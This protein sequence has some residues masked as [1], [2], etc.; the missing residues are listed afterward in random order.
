M[1]RENI[2]RWLRGVYTSATDIGEAMSYFE[3]RCVG[4][5]AL[6]VDYEALAESFLRP[7]SGA[8][9][10]DGRDLERSRKIELRALIGSAIQRNSNWAG[11]PRSD[12]ERMVFCW[13]AEHVYGAD[14]GADEETGA[15]HAAIESELHV[16]KRT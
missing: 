1:D 16:S 7:S 2:N 11:V 4:S 5:A 6:G 14:V 10:G 9:S 8:K 3:A 12:R 15:A 13:L